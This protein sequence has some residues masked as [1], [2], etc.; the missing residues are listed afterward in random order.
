V[1]DG[2]TARRNGGNYNKTDPKQIAR[3]A[4]VFSVKLFGKHVLL[5]EPFDIPIQLEI[6]GLGSGTGALAAER[7]DIAGK[8]RIRCSCSILDRPWATCG[9]N[10]IR[11]EFESVMFVATYRKRMAR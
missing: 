3:G 7:I 9:G 11:Y 5:K 1:L 8:A 10:R 2:D 4:N 6:N